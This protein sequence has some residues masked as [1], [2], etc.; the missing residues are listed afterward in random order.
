[1]DNLLAESN[2]VTNSSDS[3]IHI[4]SKKLI[5][6]NANFTLNCIFDYNVLQPYLFWG[7]RKNEEVFLE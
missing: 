7:F 4:K 6:K 5:I 1:M 2:I 3:V